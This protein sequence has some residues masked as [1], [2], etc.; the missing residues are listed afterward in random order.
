MD[1]DDPRDPLADGSFDDVPAADAPLSDVFTSDLFTT[2][3]F[4]DELV[5]IQADDWDI[6]ADLIWGSAD[7]GPAAADT[8]QDLPLP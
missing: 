7:T 3:P 4:A 1:I 8:D 2:D 5:G 6:D